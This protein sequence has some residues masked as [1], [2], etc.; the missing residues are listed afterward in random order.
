M[1]C[2]KE[3]CACAIGLAV[4]PPIRLNWQQAGTSSL[5]SPIL[6][7]MTFPTCVASGIWHLPK[8]PREV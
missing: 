6:A 1:S 3:L 7:E 5:E 2:F 8:H 4:D